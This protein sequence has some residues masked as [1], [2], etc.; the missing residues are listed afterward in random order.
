MILVHACVA[1]MRCGCDLV[2][3]SKLYVSQPAADFVA[4]LAR[5]IHD[6]LLRPGLAPRALTV[7]LAALCDPACRDTV[8]VRS[9]TVRPG[10]L[11]L[12]EALL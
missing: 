12:I 6:P 7:L 4:C 11:M 5:M 3:T 1:R 8:Q 2:R 10:V 9:V